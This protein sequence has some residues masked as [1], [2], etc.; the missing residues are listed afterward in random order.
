MKIISNKT[1]EDYQRLLRK[2]QS[3]ILANRWLAEFDWLLEPFWDYINK[4]DGFSPMIDQVRDKMRRN[5]YNYQ[6]RIRK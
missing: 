4:S 5:L 6:S 1:Y 2:E 3:L